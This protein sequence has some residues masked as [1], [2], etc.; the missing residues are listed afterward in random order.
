MP[1][2]L[3]FLAIFIGTPVLLNVLSGGPICLDGWQSSSIGTQGACSHH[4][5]I[6]GQPEIFFIS[7]AIALGGLAVL[8]RREI[9]DA[10]ATRQ[11]EK[12]RDIDTDPKP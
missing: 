6:D 8:R 3:I 5:G 1:N 10:F 12:K 7:A 11:S 4:G 2:I 9:R